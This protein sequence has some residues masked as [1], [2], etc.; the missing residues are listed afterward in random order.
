MKA[1]ALIRLAVLLVCTA[2]LSFGTAIAHGV[3]THTG[4]GNATTVTV[5]HEDGS[6]LAAESFTVHS[7]KGGSAFMTG[8]TDR[9]GRAIFIPDVSGKWEVKIFSDDGHGAIVSI[10]VD[11]DALSNPTESE[12]ME[13]GQAQ[14]MITGVSVL[15]GIFGLVS[16]MVNRKR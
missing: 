16:F 15:F 7:P 3:H 14:K 1:S 12:N 2:C 5:T 9:L 6:P 4:S 11:L 10:D 13:M 8:K